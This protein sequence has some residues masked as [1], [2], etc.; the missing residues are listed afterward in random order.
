MKKKR[1]NIKA[2]AY[3]EKGMKL[4]SAVNNY[5]K[6]HP[7]QKYFSEKAGESEHKSCLHAELGA[8]LKARGKSIYK[9]FVERYFDDGSPALAKPCKSCQEAIKAFGVQIV[10]YTSEE[11][12]Q[13]YE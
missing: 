3:N 8:L 2:T 12:I 11:G 4:S 5:S 13:S 9:L 1:Y 10:E 7:L 6:T